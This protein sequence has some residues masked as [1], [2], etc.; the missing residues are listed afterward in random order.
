MMLLPGLREL[1]Q[2]QFTDALKRMEA[3]LTQFHEVVFVD[4]NVRLN[5]LWVSVRPRPGVILDIACAMRFE[6]P[7]A[8]LVAQRPPWAQ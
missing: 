6:L 8:L 5:L 1:P 4:L 2:V 3:V 7:R